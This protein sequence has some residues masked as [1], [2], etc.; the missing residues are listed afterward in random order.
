M[1]TKTLFILAA[2]ALTF[3]AAQATS[4]QPKTK[5][6]MIYQEQPNGDFRLSLYGSNRS[7]V[8]EEKDI[9]IVQQ[10]DAINPIV[11]ECKH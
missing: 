8:C 11:L 2:L 9:Q 3:V 5:I 6:Q 4:T 1:T 7:L 10:G